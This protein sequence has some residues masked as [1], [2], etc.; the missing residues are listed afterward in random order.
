[1]HVVIGYISSLSTA[2][3]IA[4]LEAKLKQIDEESLTPSVTKK[5]ELV[6]RTV[7][8]MCKPTC[9]QCV[10]WGGGGGGGTNL[11]DSEEVHQHHVQESNSHMTNKY[12]V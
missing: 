7:D 12:I 3:K 5:P 4:A 10:C 2:A 8:R 9:S 11:T 6:A 1:M